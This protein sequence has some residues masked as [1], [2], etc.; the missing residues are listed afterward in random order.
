MEEFVLTLFLFSLI[1]SRG[2]TDGGKRSQLPCNSEQTE[3]AQV[4]TEDYEEVRNC[5]IAD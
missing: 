4:K 2:G 1:F 5:E 3:S